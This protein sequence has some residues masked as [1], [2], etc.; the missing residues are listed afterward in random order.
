MSTRFATAFVSL[1]AAA[2]APAAQE[3]APAAAPASSPAPTPA[4]LRSIFLAPMYHGDA[5]PQVRT[6]RG[7]Q[8][9]W[10][11]AEAATADVDLTRDAAYEL[12]REVVV[13]LEAGV[14]FDEL[15]RNHSSLPNR[16]VGGVLGTFAPGMLGPK[17]DAFVLGA[18]LG[19]VS[20][21]FETPRGWLVV[22]RVESH[23]AARGLLV[24]ANREDAADRC[25]ALLA[26]ARAGEE[27]A[28]LCA[29]ASD[30]PLTKSRAGALAI[31]ERGPYDQLL[32]AAA[33]ALPVGATS[34]PIESPLGWHLVQ[35]VP[36]ESLDPALADPMWVRAR[37]ILVAQSFVPLGAPSA[38]RSSERAWQGAAKLYERVLAGED[39]GELARQFCDDFGGRERRGDLGWIHRRH[40]G[41]AHFLDELW[42]A[43]PGELLEPVQSNAGWV[44]LRRE[45]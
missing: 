25:R 43:A 41:K 24:A 14:D 45:W 39:M 42:K 13:R 16:Q 33:F 6:L 23:A 26:R 19:A 12:A 22:Q 27:F 20:E 8:V 2:L 28:K 11:G 31:F 37:A 34:E 32:K 44:L 5:P 18:E 4:G 17:L 29:E 38:E 10:K 40:P 21:P 30:D 1:V 3:P 9:S 7:I 15:S 35:R 36:I